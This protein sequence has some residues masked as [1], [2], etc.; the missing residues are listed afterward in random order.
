MHTLTAALHHKPL[1]LILVTKKLILRSR[2]RLPSPGVCIITR[3]KEKA[4]ANLQG[5]VA[6]VT[7]SSKGIGA[8][9]AQRLAADGASV[10]VNYARSAT[11]AEAL[12]KRIQSAGGKAVAIQ[13]D[14]SSPANVKKLISA[15]VQ[16]FDRLDI[17]VNNAGVYKFV[18]LEAITVEHIDQHFNL[19][20]KALLLATQAAVPHFGPEGGVVINI[21]SVAAISPTP[22]SSVY[23][24]TKAAVDVITRVLAMELGP[25]KIRVVGVSPGVTVTEG[26]DAMEEMDEATQ[27]YAISRTPLGRLGTP[28]DIAKAV[29]FVASSEAGWITGETL[30]VGGGLR[31]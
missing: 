25:K 4:M 15:T 12:I 1:S 3:R 5:K 28:E 20:V 23:A 27:K 18:P 30:Q 8:E 14:L 22:A 6:I 10:V 11:P 31:F 24:G 16:A 17:L 9:I 29:A 21:S 19:N 26:L 7:G 13:A 2:I